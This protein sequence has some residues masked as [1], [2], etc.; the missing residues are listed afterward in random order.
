MKSSFSRLALMLVVPNLLWFLNCKREETPPPP[1]AAEA[2]V[3]SGD[4]AVSPGALTRVK[5]E[6]STDCCE[7]VWVV[8]SSSSPRSRCQSIRMRVLMWSLFSSIL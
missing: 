4:V 1:K 7:A 3:A 5:G 2:P 6:G 8:W